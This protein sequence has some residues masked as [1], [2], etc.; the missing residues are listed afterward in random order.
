MTLPEV[1][2]RS[3]RHDQK[4]NRAPR[5]GRL[6]LALALLA[7]PCFADPSGGI[8]ATTRSITVVE[9]D[10][11]AFRRV[12]NAEE[13][14]QSRVGQIAQDD[15]GFMWFG[16]Q[17]GLNRFDGHGR[18][19][20]APDA[21]A[22][23]RLAGVFVYAML[24]DRSGRLWIAS[25]QGLDILD[26]RSGEFTRV[27]Y[28]GGARISAVIQSIYEDRTGNFWLSTT[29]GLYGLD[30]KGRTRVHFRHDAGNPESLGSN[31]VK[32]AS[33]ARDGTFWVTNGAGLEALEGSSGR[34]LLRV[35]LPESREMG[36][37]EDRLGVFWIYHAG[38][39]GLTSFDRASKTL[40]TYRF[41]DSAGKALPR[42]GIYTSLEDREGGLWFGTGGAGLMRLDAGN[43]QFIR[44]RNNSGDPQSLGG[45]DVTTLFQDRQD[46]IWVA[47]HGMPLNLFPARALPFRKLPSRP[48]NSYGR[49]ESMVNSVLEVD[50]KSLWI[51]FVG[52]LSS[53]DLKT[54]KH[55]NLREQL[56]LN[57]DVISMAQDARGRVWLGT[58]GSGL[59]R[60]DPSGEARRYQ[61][62][63]ADPG[64]I[65]GD[66]IN[67]IL[68]DHAQTLWLATWGGLSRFDETRG[69]FETYKTPDMDPKYLALAEDSGHQLWLATHLYGLQRFD[70]G[71]EKFVTYPPAGAGGGLSNSRVNAVHVD[72]RGVVWAGTQN[73]LDALDPATGNLRSYHSGDGMPGNAVSCILEDEEGGIWLGTNAGIS[74][75][76]VSTGEFR[77]FTKADGLTGL[78]F[79]GW[80][81]CHRTPSGEMYFAGFA[82]ATAFKPEQ[83]RGLSFVPPVEFTDLVISGR[84][85][86]DLPPDS[87][88]LILPELRKLT[89]PYARNSFSAGFAALS[90]ANPTS[91]RYRFRLTGLEERWHS[92]GSDRRIASYNSLSPGDYRLEVQAAASGGPWS[93]A[94]T[95]EFTILKPWW[96]TTQFR[97]AVAVLVLALAWLAYR[98]H[99]R[100]VTRRFEIRLDERVA[101]RTRIAR[102]LHDSLLQGFHGL[103]FRLQAVRNLLPARP[104]EAA[105]SLDE[106]M[107][108]GD[109]T[110][111]QARVAVTDLRSFASGEADLESVLRA[112]VQGLPMP[113]HADAPDYRIV[114]DGKPRSMVPLVRDEVLQIAREAFRN[115][116]LH[117]R[118][119]TVQVEID[120]GTECFSL[121]V[122]DDGVGLSKN[123]ISHG[124]DGH[125][126]LQGMRERTRQ[127]GGSLEIRSEDAVGTVVELSIP[128]ARAYAKPVRPA[129]EKQYPPQ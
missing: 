44:Y 61:H 101:E 21:R 68:V 85:Y 110:V 80:G 115:A 118:A 57:S 35:P 62:D 102:E 51:S 22:T 19:M 114:V 86:P 50:G 65:A 4:H 81:S 117:A 7:T 13:F 32:F 29:A 76:D 94:K 28:A 111:E 15:K 6:L 67:D 88:P 124:R 3:A 100:Q 9:G 2:T 82:G 91:N 83:V 5:K 79:T 39:S 48:A 107:T 123:L 108:R 66:V 74:R 18:I 63:P 25:D 59:V 52:M 64:S 49:A 72:R 120:W 129:R 73:G 26:P 42:F 33:E 70:P 14:S 121:R 43:R 30:S 93:K 31:D 99:V 90:Y 17:Y 96:L 105:H 20:F 24:K 75:L 54:G 122:R 45:D 36:F 104:L 47:L 89:L 112:M 12:E 103:M 92:A 87:R 69:R 128:A 46:N 38:G 56:Q 11:I 41:I 60:V 106:V 78:D 27:E 77:N 55:T 16:T 84:N 23:N 8:S 10:D 125:W 37:I 58:V 1:K 95:L 126:G 109:E 71:T 40:S 34:V 113:A 127:V 119:E 116:V 98:L 97:L 53:V